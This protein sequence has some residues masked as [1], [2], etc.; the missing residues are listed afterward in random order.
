MFHRL[1]RERDD[2]LVAGCEQMHLHVDTKAHRAALIRP[3]VYSKLDAIWAT[4][5][6]LA[7]PA[8]AGRHIGMAAR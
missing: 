1:F 7:A 2:Q 3:E 8:Q 4:H 5:A 6:T